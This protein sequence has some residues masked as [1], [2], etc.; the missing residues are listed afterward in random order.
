MFEHIELLNVFYHN[1]QK[2]GRLVMN[3]NN[4]ALFE[5]DAHWLKSGFSNAPY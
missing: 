3:D 4:L 5:Y 2:V 1:N